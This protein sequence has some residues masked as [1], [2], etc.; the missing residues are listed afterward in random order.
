MKS[1]HAIDSFQFQTKKR[2]EGPQSEDYKSLFLKSFIEEDNLYYTDD[3]MK[4]TDKLKLEKI[5]EIKYIKIRILNCIIIG[6]ENILNEIREI[7]RLL[8][9]ISNN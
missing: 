4:I 3:H 7:Q 8:I 1:I 9:Y 2:K 6:Y 5:S